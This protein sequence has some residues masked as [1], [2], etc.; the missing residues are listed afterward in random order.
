MM[1]LFQAFELSG[2]SLHCWGTVRAP[3]K[4]R[5]QHALTKSLR[6]S[7]HC[8]TYIP[9]WDCLIPNVGDTVVLQLQSLACVLTCKAQNHENI[10]ESYLAKLKAM[11]LRLTTVITDQST[12]EEIL[13]HLLQFNARRVWRRAREVTFCLKT[14]TAAAKEVSTHSF[15]QKWR[16]FL[17]K[18]EQRTALC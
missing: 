9:I 5:Q 1:I 14:T 4:L 15:Y 18:E 17:H 12:Y 6:Q 13:A 10:W 16:V 7:A 3:L 11:L 2:Q 8:T